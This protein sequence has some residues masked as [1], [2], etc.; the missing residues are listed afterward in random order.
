M[1]TGWSYRVLVR[2]AHGVRALLADGID[3]CLPLP[4]LTP[5]GQTASCVL[6]AFDLRGELVPVISI[7]LLLGE[8]SP[9]A[10]PTDLVLV[11]LA[12]GFPVGLYTPRPACIER[13][14]VAAAPRRGEIAL[15]D[16]HLT[17]AGPDAQA[18]AERRLARFERGLTPQ[19]LHR[20]GQRA[21]RY[22]EFIGPH[23]RSADVALPAGS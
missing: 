17:V 9:R 2:T 18:V 21:S 1:D 23:Y 12:A 13:L 3:A 8:P 15:G 16:L 11:V 19:A 7:G 4:R 6:G 22:G 14:P 5:L 20:L 10:A